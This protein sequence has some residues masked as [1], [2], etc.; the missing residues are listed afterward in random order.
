MPN[1]RLR[2]CAAEHMR[3]AISVLAVI[4]HLECF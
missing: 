1:E 4:E 3:A 2:R